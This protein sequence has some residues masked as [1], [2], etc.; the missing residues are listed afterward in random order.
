[1]TLTYTTVNNE[2]LKLI[3]FEKEKK[4]FKFKF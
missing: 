1:M 2:I 4:I 3:L